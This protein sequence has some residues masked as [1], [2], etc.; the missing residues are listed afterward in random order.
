MTS[1]ALTLPRYRGQSRP[2]IGL[3][4]GWQV[5]SGTVHSFLS[6]VFRGAAAAAQDY[7]CN[8]LIGCG[9]QQPSLTE[10]GPALPVRAP[11]ADFVPV[12]PWNTDGL[13]VFSPF[14]ELKSYAYFQGLLDAGFPL[15]YGGDHEEGPAVMIDNE[16]G[17]E[18]AVLHL[19]AHGRRRIALIAG[20]DRPTGDSAG[21]LRGY[22]AGLER[23]GL[24]FDPRLVLHGNHK[25]DDSYTAARR[26]LDSGLAFDALIGSNDDAAIAAMTALHEAG[27]LVPDDVA[28]IG[29]DDRQEALA[30][31]PQLSSVH[32]PMF[33]MGYRSVELLYRIINRQ[34]PPTAQI[35]IPAHLVVRES[36]GC[37]PGGAVLQQSEGSPRL[38]NA[39]P[40][41]SSASDAA[42]VRAMTARVAAELRRMEREQVQTLCRRLLEALRASLRDNDPRDFRLALQRILESVQSIDDD[43]YPWQSAITVLE[44]MLLLYLPAD[45]ALQA[46]RLLHNAR[47]AISEIQRG[48]AAQREVEVQRVLTQ[49]SAMTAQYVSAQTEE[50][51]YDSVRQL[52]TSMGVRSG[53][54]VFYEASGDDPYASSLLRFV[55]P[56]GSAPQRFDTRSFPPPGLFG[57]VHPLHMAVLPLAGDE[58]MLGYMAFETGDLN[59]LGLLVYQVFAA[60]RGVR[61]NQ[62]ANQARRAAEEANQL[63]SRFLSIV[64]H[65]LRTP[66]NLIYGL[67][68][69]ILTESRAISA[70]ERAVQQTDLERMFIAAQHL[71]SLIRD[72]LDLA[73]SDVGRLHITT[74][75]LDLLP[76]LR[77]TAQIGEKLAQDKNLRWETCLPTSLPAICGDRTRLRQVVLNL[78]YNAVKFTSE[79]GVQL[80]AGVVDGQVHIA[81]RDTGLGIAPEEQQSIFDEFHRTHRSTARGFGGLG[82]GLA[83]CKRLVELHGGKIGVESS[84]EEGAGSTFSLSLPVQGQPRT[85]PVDVALTALSEASARSEAGTRVLLLVRQMENGQALQTALSQR[86]FQVTLAAPQPGE[87]WLAGCV[88]PALP[89]QVV[90]DAELAAERG[91]EMLKTLR[92]HPATRSTPVLFESLAGDGGALLELNL[93]PKPLPGEMLAQTVLPHLQTALDRPVLIVDDDPAMLHLHSRMVE[94]IA[95]SRAVLTAPH[96]RA[97]LEILRQ[98]TPALV[99]LDLMMPEMDGFTLLQAMQELPRARGVPVIVLTSQNMTEEDM[100][101]L[102]GSVAGVL[103]KGMFDTG[104]TIERITAVLDH[105]QRP[106]AETQ[107]IVRHAMGFIH[108][109]YADPIT[110]AEIA[111]EVGLS[112][113]HLTRCFQQETGLTPM[114]YLNRYRVRQACLLLCSTDR[115]ITDI[116][117]DVGFSNSGYFT[118]VFKEETGLTP[119]AYAQKHGAPR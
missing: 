61:L 47:V 79:G 25:I 96:G 91:T 109:R 112:E 111:D 101:R 72:V 73:S 76:L 116:A 63:K 56:G 2:T 74:E 31:S 38:A 98:Q 55:M 37:L 8:L 83:I 81:V 21:R 108:R 94:T 59:L 66:L 78:I 54:I 15:V 6:P 117:L 33:E 110:R 51:I 65:E 86:G 24:D 20:F 97:A 52:M 50:Q 34:A 43:L 7:D 30:Q 93:L 84:G 49:I 3:L 4:S 17:L 67:S 89:D 100:Q 58:G 29:F 39:V 64:S 32:Y 82:L 26:L 113:R 75:T 107:R 92:E 14:H 77:D 85:L 23:A 102:N 22:R 5:Y 53:C 119:S 9:V 48:R 10:S 71:E 28:V 45:G 16:G 42:I 105:K 80:W 57:S 18:E 36:C 62:A 11:W 99:L 12:G 106:S 87:D 46:N 13:V 60:L 41:Q 40:Q 118:R 19:A 104:E 114:V 35:R 27:L 88:L 1:T 69:M 103:A 70:D 68:N 115:P 95:G 44:E 90:L